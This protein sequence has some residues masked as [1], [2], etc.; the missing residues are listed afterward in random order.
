MFSRR[1]TCRSTR[2][3]VPRTFP[4]G[5]SGRPGSKYLTDIRRAAS[6]LREIV[7][8]AR[9][10]GEQVRVLALEPFRHR[11]ES[12]N[13]THDLGP[14]GRRDAGA[15]IAGRKPVDA[16]VESEQRTEDQPAHRDGDRNEAT[17]HEDGNGDADDAPDSIPASGV[18]LRP[19][20]RPGVNPHE[21]QHRVERS[22]QRRRRRSHELLRRP[23]APF[24]L[25]L[26]NEILSDVALGPVDE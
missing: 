15:T 14:T 25:L 4:S 1:A 11:V 3:M 6:G 19:G 8:H 5:G 16:V 9:E 23:A 7:G 2:A 22:V 20:Q 10:E 13:R 18:G 26:R 12:L 21:L 24:G 17:R